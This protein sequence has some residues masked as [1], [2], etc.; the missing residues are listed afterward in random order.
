MSVFFAAD[1][2]LA[3]YIRSFTF[4]AG[5]KFYFAIKNGQ[6]QFG[7]LNKNQI[8]NQ[9]R[10]ICFSLLRR[11]SRRGP[12]KSIGLSR[13]VRPI[14]PPPAIEGK[15]KV[16]E[17]RER[18]RER[19]REGFDR[20]WRATCWSVAVCKTEA[21]IGEQQQWSVPYGCLY[22][23]FG[24]NWETFLKKLL[25]NEERKENYARFFPSR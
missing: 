1:N 19:E 9:I 5:G 11:G 20:G 18:E 21:Y 12:S 3:V 4:E 17:E 24:N 23:L 7:T 8:A 16:Q 2:F 22:I 25:Y 6:Q 14:P 10:G 15:V 13:T